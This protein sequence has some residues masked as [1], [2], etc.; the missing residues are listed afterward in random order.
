MAAD[1][2]DTQEDARL[3]QAIR[4]V[5][6]ADQYL[7]KERI[8]YLKDRLKA[9]QEWRIAEERES[10]ELA[11]LAPLLGCESKVLEDIEWE[12]A[13]IPLDGIEQN[14][15]FIF[16][17]DQVKQQQM[18]DNLNKQDTNMPNDF[19]TDVRKKIGSQKSTDNQPKKRKFAIYLGATLAAAGI[20]MVI[21]AGS[22]ATAGVVPIA[23]G[24]VGSVLIVG[25][26]LY[27]A[28]KKRAR[29][30]KIL[31]ALYA[32]SQNAMDLQLSELDGEQRQKKLAKLSSK[33]K[34][35]PQEY[36]KNA[37][38]IESQAVGLPWY[39][40]VGP[41]LARWST[42]VAVSYLATSVAL[43]EVTSAIVEGVAQIR[44]KLKE[45]N[46]DPNAVAEFK[47][48]QEWVSALLEKRE[49]G[50]GIVERLGLKLPNQYKVDFY[51]YLRIEECYAG[52]SKKSIDK[53]N[54]Q[55]QRLII[56]DAIRDTMLKIFYT[57]PSTVLSLVDK[58]DGITVTNINNALKTATDNLKA[59][60]TGYS[61]LTSLEIYFPPDG[62]DDYQR[63]M[64]VAGKTEAEQKKQAELFKGI[65]AIKQAIMQANK[66][67]QAMA[68]AKG[69]AT[70]PEGVKNKLSLEMN[71]LMEQAESA[72]KIVEVELTELDIL[73]D[74]NEIRKYHVESCRA[75]KA[76][77]GDEA[78]SLSECVKKAKFSDLVL[79]LQDERLKEFASKIA[80][81]T[82]IK[83]KDK[84]V[85]AE[86]LKLYNVGSD[87]EISNQ[88]KLAFFQ[89]LNAM[90]EDD[91][92][93]KQLKNSIVKE[94]LEFTDFSKLNGDLIDDLKGF[95]E[96][97]TNN[98][99]VYHSQR[100]L[101]EQ[102]QVVLE[103]MQKALVLSIPEMQKT[104]G[105]E[106][107][108][109]LKRLAAKRKIDY[110]APYKP[111][112]LFS[113][114]YVSKLFKKAQDA[115]EDVKE[116][117]ENLK[118]SKANIS[119][120]ADGLEKIAG[121]IG[122]PNIQTSI[123]ST[124]EAL[125]KIKD[126]EVPASMPGF[127][128]IVDSFFDK[129]KDAR[130][131]LNKDNQDRVT[132]S[133][134]SIIDFLRKIPEPYKA[135]T[136]PDLIEKI[137]SIYQEIV[138]LRSE[139]SQLQA[140]PGN[141]A[142]AAKMKKI[143]ARL[144]EL[145][146]NFDAFERNIEAMDLKNKVNGLP[147]G[148]PMKSELQ[149]FISSFNVFFKQVKDIGEELNKVAFLGDF[150]LDDFL[151][152]CSAAKGFGGLQNIMHVLPKS[153]QE[154]EKFKNL[155]MHLD[156]IF[157]FTKTHPT[158]MKKLAE[159]FNAAGVPMDNLD[160]FAKTFNRI[161]GISEDISMVAN[162]FTDLNGIRADVAGL[163]KLMQVLETGVGALG[164][165]TG[166]VQTPELEKARH[167]FE[168][169]KEKLER[170]NSFKHGIE[171]FSKDSGFEDLDVSA[172]GLPKKAE[173]AQLIDI[174][175]GLTAMESRLQKAGRALGSE[176]NDLSV[177]RGK[178]MALSV[179][180]NTLLSPSKSQ[181]KRAKKKGDASSSMGLDFESINLKAVELDAVI[182]KLETLEKSGAD[183]NNVLPHLYAL[184][185]TVAVMHAI[186]Y[187][188]P[189]TLS[190]SLTDL[191]EK[192]F[193]LKQEIQFI[194][195]KLN[196]FEEFGAK[197]AFALENIELLK[198]Q[199]ALKGQD[200]KNIK[201]AIFE[202]KR[203]G[204]SFSKSG[205]TVNLIQ[206]NQPPI[207]DMMENFS[208]DKE[209]VEKIIIEA[210]SLNKK[211]EIIAAVA[212]VEYSDIAIKL[213]P[214][215]DAIKN[216]YL[217]DVKF[218]LEVLINQAQAQAAEE[219]NMKQLRPRLSRL[220]N[221][222]KRLLALKQLNS[223]TSAMSNINFREPPYSEILQS[224]GLS[225][226]MV[227]S[228]VENTKNL[229]N[230]SLVAIDGALA[231]LES[232][233]TS[234]KDPLLRRVEVHLNGRKPSNFLSLIM[235]N[236]ASLEDIIEKWH[237][238]DPQYNGLVFWELWNSTKSFENLVNE[239]EGATLTEKQ[240]KLLLASTGGS[241]F[242]EMYS[243]TNMAAIVRAQAAAVELKDLLKSPTL[244]VSEKSK[245]S[246]DSLIESHHALLKQLHDYHR[247]VRVANKLKNKL[248]TADGKP[249][250]ID[251]DD[252]EQLNQLR[253]RVMKLE[254]T[255]QAFLRY[256][257]LIGSS[258]LQ[259]QADNPESKKVK[260]LVENF[261]KVLDKF[262]ILN[263][264]QVVHQNIELAESLYQRLHAN[265]LQPS[266]HLL[267]HFGHK[268]SGSKP[269]T[270]DV[271][272]PRPDF[273]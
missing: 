86:F 102:K 248:D 181:Q 139:L 136:I 67:M 190:S 186:Q 106:P 247:L 79:L 46:Q 130:E 258:L 64:L 77:W 251:S 217:K 71:G 165:A 68:K 147:D 123:E 116:I 211:Q 80:K 213:A 268:R 105:E 85:L 239:F 2:K 196:A 90:N 54:A 18:M 131:M 163:E 62:N 243:F 109:T 192:V 209:A 110:G 66:T 97:V 134:G 28:K 177:W 207:S 21:A 24:V 57:H 254:E 173:L 138:N 204:E 221:M 99:Y 272:R 219:I 176:D 142:N 126:I 107:T 117:R 231:T 101:I 200:L 188:D 35:N 230:D 30:S 234:L 70:V 242:S 96:Y 9:I 167:T 220:Q 225:D 65:L 87:I 197:T 146:K 104:L 271:P 260:D 7:A 198:K 11:E 159:L 245:K 51:D 55:I 157:A 227:N 63:F 151:Y 171:K 41:R 218:E 270:E 115:F 118:L 206:F 120:I 148:F 1:A 43:K 50:I 133:I 45:K 259:I 113:L 169:A 127:D 16:A 78:Q 235:D 210:E 12:K 233:I 161:Q 145:R 8:N 19:S 189:K 42:N 226:S 3:E 238:K 236:S 6:G 92:Q 222:K 257:E 48:A 44:G 58:Q 69:T 150:P 76:L 40:R 132:N 255:L 158:E 229:P 178:G 10:I 13:P 265:E 143:V 32:K 183:P 212:A 34:D 72:A 246:V 52:E 262:Y 129:A 5:L 122:D 191:S 94:K 273:H 20:G 26:G 112:M 237:K 264:P 84:G 100:V 154:L 224:L 56:G 27:Y 152:I 170:L 175:K 82:K 22:V 240:Q 215:V 17:I 149:N 95:K 180:M 36:Q 223:M 199:L 124:L 39:K 61:C 108:P 256:R 47:T 15:A 125:K 187:R 75:F 91:S 137:R 31:P 164:T 250:T 119:S 208:I 98:E 182:K 93:L 184:R 194:I 144:K 179:A 29:V 37:N 263:G 160:T 103:E 114:D 14:K 185:A 241:A 156:K 155:K 33:A 89:K 23:L 162:V 193:V 253:Q 59:F 128:T 88:K 201:Q 74:T 261:S 38:L 141:Y 244:K 216:S 267:P 214:L 83:G 252:V 73:K 203:I 121:Y 153:T 228:A 135:L 205:L 172:L 81:D 168:Q 49:K 174:T 60:N 266:K 269:K 4:V 195:N 202:L 25:A 111:S 166:H 249:E 232:A 53:F 140:D